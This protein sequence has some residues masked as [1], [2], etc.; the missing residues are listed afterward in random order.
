M[1]CRST[2]ILIAALSQVKPIL[3]NFLEITAN[4]EKEKPTNH[5]KI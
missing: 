3:I 4:T 1:Q 5:T 2:Y